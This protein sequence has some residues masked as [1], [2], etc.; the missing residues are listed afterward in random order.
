MCVSEL[1][2]G[3]GA[4]ENTCMCVCARACDRFKEV[5]AER[6]RRQGW[7]D[8]MNSF[9]YRRQDADEPCQHGEGGEG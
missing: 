3:G 9:R 7:E 5:G 2:V 4:G 1:R 6:V 8:K